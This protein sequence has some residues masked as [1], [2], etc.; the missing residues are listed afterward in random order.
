[1]IV[2][3]SLLVLLSVLV[4]PSFGSRQNQQIINKFNSIS[5]AIKREVTDEIFSEAE[6]SSKEHTPAERDAK[7]LE[8]EPPPPTTASTIIE[9]E[10][11]TTTDDIPTSTTSIPTSSSTTTPSPYTYTVTGGSVT[12]TLPYEGSPTPS[13][14][15]VSPMSFSHS[16]AATAYPVTTV[17]YPHPPIPTYP[18]SAP[19]FNPHTTM[20]P[21]YIPQ[22]SSLPRR[23]SPTTFTLVEDPLHSVHHPPRKAQFGDQPFSPTLPPFVAPTAHT[24]VPQGFSAASN[25]QPFLSQ[26]HPTPFSFQPLLPQAPLGPPQAPVGPP[27]ETGLPFSLLHS[28]PFT[29]NSKLAITFEDDPVQEDTEEIPTVE[30]KEA[31]HMEKEQ[32]EQKDDKKE[33]EDDKSQNSKE[34]NQNN[35]VSGA[36]PDQE[37]RR[38]KQ[39]FDEPN[40]QPIFGDQGVPS[41]GQ[42]V[43]Q[44]IQQ[45]QL[46]QFKP[47]SVGSQQQQQFLSQAQ[48][49]FPSQAQQQF[50]G[51]ATSPQLAA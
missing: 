41:G 12:P 22:P 1:M 46:L 26:V 9:L 13:P 37:A 8:I 5:R 10:E 42:Q 20:A 7:P 39:F 34:E 40:P 2:L 30:E 23:P 11:N 17:T 31:E 32:D 35:E 43:D 48:Q 24:L 18:P 29:P 6:G 47:Q 28:A 49:Q 15:H 45:L 50:P 27:Q 3:T 36:F 25:S 33:E 38:P 51:Q 16:P 21:V 4:T 19:I 44:A 14:Y